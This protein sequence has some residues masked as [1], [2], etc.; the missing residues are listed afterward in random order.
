VLGLGVPQA[1]F[2]ELTTKAFSEHGG[3]TNETGKIALW[4]ERAKVVQP[5]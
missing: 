4:H 2:V 5:R 1:R 3:E